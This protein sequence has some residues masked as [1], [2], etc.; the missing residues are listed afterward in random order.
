MAHCN[1]ILNQMLKILPRHEFQKSVDTHQGDKKVR[2]LSCWAQLVSMM[3]GQ[4]S[5][6]KSLRDLV[7]SLQVQTP[8]L[9]HLGIRKVKR[10][11]LS[12]ANQK[13]SFLIYENLFHRLYEKVAAVPRSHGFRFKHPLYAID[14]TT[15]DLCLSLFPWATF[16][17]TKAAVKLHTQLNLAGHIPSFVSISQGKTHEA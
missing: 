16:R 3:F 11:T 8:M 4:L 13:R 6:R 7:T 5:F 15:L 17:K 12:D 2:N 10:S 9:Y 1:T 14:T